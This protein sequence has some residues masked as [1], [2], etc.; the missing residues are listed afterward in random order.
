M[1]DINYFGKMPWTLENRATARVMTEVLKI[2]LRKALREDKSGVYGI[3]VS[4]DAGII[5]SNYFKFEIFFQCATDLVDTL[6]NEA[7]R[8]IEIIKKEGPDV[9]TLEKVKTVL[10]SEYDQKV[11]KNDYWLETLAE[12]YGF[13]K[14][15]HEELTEY[16]SV[17][18]DVSA[19]DVRKFTRKK[20]KS[21]KMLIAKMYPESFRNN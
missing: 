13:E 17:V 9:E 21:E 3:S 1:V 10:K 5:P 2:N 12:I 4:S 6:I 7:N 19:K 18:M 14:D 8:Q 20:L 16:M 15:I 11:L